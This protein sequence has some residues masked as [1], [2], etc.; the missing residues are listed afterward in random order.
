MSE[1]AARLETTPEEL[2]RRIAMVLDL[3][4]TRLQA[5]EV[6]GISPD[7]VLQYVKG[8]A[9]PAFITLARLAHPHR[10]RLDW[11]ATGTGPMHHDDSAPAARDVVDAQ[12]AWN[13]LY[14]LARHLDLGDDPTQFAEVVMR[15]MRHYQARRTAPERMEATAPEL[16]DFA[17]AQLK[18]RGGR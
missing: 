13:V 9:K 11:L 6:A 14:F 4:P 7:Q 2:G 16:I 10:V 18:R 12:V 15:L 3:Y 5:A 1:G 17:L 8:A